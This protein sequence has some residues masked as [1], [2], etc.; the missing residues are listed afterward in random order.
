[1]L[2]HNTP[3]QGYIEPRETRIMILLAL[4][5]GVLL[6]FNAYDFVLLL[7]PEWRRD[8]RSSAVAEALKLDH[9]AP[10]VGPH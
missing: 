8:D 5:I 1:M 2:I 4:C 9:L 3:F 10:G 7:K 6:L